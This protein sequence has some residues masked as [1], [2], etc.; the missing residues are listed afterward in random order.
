MTVMRH[1]LL[2]VDDEEFVRNALVRAL[3]SEDYEI[4]TAD[5]PKAACEALAERPA[6]IVLSDF[7]MPRM[8]GLELLQRVREQYPDSIRIMLTGH[9]DTETVID[10]VNNSEIY[11][12]LTKPWNDEEL[13]LVLRL[14]ASHLD[15]MRE[16]RRL[17]D[18]V[19]RQAALLRGIEGKHPGITKVA[20]TNDGAVVI[21]EAELD[22]LVRNPA[23]G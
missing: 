9:A 6:D 17:V 21:D 23:V 10:A 2:I 11:R 7:K 16:N 14:A 8:T 18:L 5:G 4:R 1:S 3:R 12:F 20:R 13:K 15:A 22:E 19:K